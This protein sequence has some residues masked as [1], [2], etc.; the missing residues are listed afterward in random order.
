MPAGN[1]MALSKAL[2]LCESTRPSHQAQSLHLLSGLAKFVAE[3]RRAAAA[4]LLQDQPTA[5]PGITCTQPRAQ[6]ASQDH[7]ASAAADA[8]SSQPT[9]HGSEHAAPHVSR[10]DQSTTAAGKG[11]VG[12]SQASQALRVGISGPPGRHAPAS[13]LLLLLLLL[14]ASVRSSLHARRRMANIPHLTP[15]CLLFSTCWYCECLRRCWEVKFD[16][17]PRNAL[18]R[19]GRT[20]GCP[21]RGSIQPTE[22]C[23]DGLFGFS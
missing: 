10:S 14:F 1:R 4:Q 9:P 7:A 3:R 2:T 23:A 21:C 13:M 17:E 20:C 12:R 19:P 5:R 22:R 16:R 8:A 11:V 18:V 15:G 6:S